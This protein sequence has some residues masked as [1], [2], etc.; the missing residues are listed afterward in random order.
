MQYKDSGRNKECRGNVG[1]TATL[2]K[3]MDSY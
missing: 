3:I 2:R 1:K